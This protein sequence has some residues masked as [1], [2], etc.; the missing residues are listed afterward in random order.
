MGRLGSPAAPSAA[1][2][3]GA[4]N[5]A[6]TAR[7]GIEGSHQVRPVPGREC[8]VVAE[9]VHERLPWDSDA[10]LDVAQRSGS[11][12]PSSRVTGEGR[13]VNVSRSR[14]VTSVV[15]SRGL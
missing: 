9:L 14:E 1:R 13:V 11:G 15:A 5:R 6:E 3:S 7:A 8:I 10:S 4:S 2:G 12:G